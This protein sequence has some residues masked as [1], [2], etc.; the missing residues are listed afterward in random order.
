MSQKKVYILLIISVLVVSIFF[1]QKNTESELIGTDAPV[2]PENWQLLTD[3]RTGVSAIVPKSL[4]FNGCTSPV[5]LGYVRED[6]P[7]YMLAAYFDVCGSSVDVAVGY[8]LSV[9]QNIYSSSDAES[10]I[11]RSSGGTCQLVIDDWKQGVWK[12]VG[13]G[14][15]ENKWAPSPCEQGLVKGFY[16]S[17]THTLVFWSAEPNLFPIGPDTYVDD[18]VKI[19]ATE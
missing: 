7:Y 11:E 12:I 17:K 9:E 3:D 5:K 19:F 16:N 18:Q 14:E 6:I 4:Y 13:D 1:I 2:I 8:S 15:P 10:A